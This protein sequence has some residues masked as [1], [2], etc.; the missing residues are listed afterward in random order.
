[1]DAFDIQAALKRKG[2][3]QKYIAFKTNTAG[4]TVSL[5][6]KSKVKSRK[7][8]DCIAAEIGEKTED[9]WP[10]CAKPKT[11]DAA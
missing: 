4:S 11:P 5:V 9:L 10:S 2:I 1:M 3:T 7:I 8:Q 6:I